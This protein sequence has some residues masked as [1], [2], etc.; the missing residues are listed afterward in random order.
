[1]TVDFFDARNSFSRKDQ[2]DDSIL[3][4]SSLYLS[5]RLLSIAVLAGALIR[6]LI[7]ANLKRQPVSQ[8]QKAGF[9]CDKLENR[10]CPALSLR[11]AAAWFVRF[12]G[13]VEEFLQIFP[14]IQLID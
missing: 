13:F 10:G 2:A 9:F 14:A 4:L 8:T 7:D 5:S 3:Y 6:A 12:A 11:C 1:L